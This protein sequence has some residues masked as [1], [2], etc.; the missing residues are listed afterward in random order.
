MTFITVL[1]DPERLRDFLEDI[2]AAG[3]DIS[4]LRLTRSKATYIVGFTSTGP[5]L[6]NYLLLQNGSNLL[7]QNG[8]RIIL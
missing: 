3:N 8:D 2:I 5:V 6:N 4:I 1:G 7:L